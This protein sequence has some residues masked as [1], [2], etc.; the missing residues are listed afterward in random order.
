MKKILL[1]VLAT[2]ALVSCSNDEVLELNRA[3]DEI[4][5]GVVTNKATRAENVYC[6][7]N[8]P[9]AFDVYATHGSKT[10]IEGDQIKYEGGKWVNK[11]GT[12]YWPNTGDVKF[13]AHVNAGT[14]FSWNTTAPTI[15]DYVVPTDVAAQKDLLYAVKTQAKPTDG[16]VI[17]NFR[18]ALSQIVFSAKNTNANLYVEI[19]GVKVCHVGN[20][21]TFTYPTEDTDEKLGEHNG[22]STDFTGTAW[23]TWAPLTSGIT[24]YPVSFDAVAV[25]GDNTV[26][27]L[28]SANEAPKEYNSKAMLLLP[29]TTTKW[30]TSV[31]AD[32]DHSTGSYFLV[33]CLIYNVAG[34]SVD[35][36][37]DVCLWGTENAGTYVA[38]ELAIPADFTWE[39]GKKYIYTFVFGKGNGGYDPNPDPTDPATPVLVPITFDITVDDF[40][41]VSGTEIESGL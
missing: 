13:F 24:T 25:D 32:P 37:N 35:K 23:G 14:D 11:S 41:P 1:G 27:S 30:N 6:N 5:F 15:D 22:G 33:N 18:H 9:T 34:T 17:M 36:T 16:Q 29:Q 40:I 7:N 19:S 28:T 31:D 21:N 12:R 20:T 8:M 38:K 3:N 26:V 10:Y 2:M 39:Q 4:T